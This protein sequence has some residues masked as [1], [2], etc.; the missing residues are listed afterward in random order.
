MRQ[1]SSSCSILYGMVSRDGHEIYSFV[2][3]VYCTSLSFIIQKNSQFSQWRPTKRATFKKEK[4]KCLINMKWVLKSWK[5]FLSRRKEFHKLCETEMDADK[6]A[7]GNKIKFPS[8]SYDDVN[9]AHWCRWEFVEFP[10]KFL[11]L[12][13]RARCGA[14]LEARKPLRIFSYACHLGSITNLLWTLRV[15]FWT[16][17]FPLPQ[18]ALF[19]LWAY[20]RQTFSRCV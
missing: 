13:P 10:H 17:I 16:F 9:E 7:L 18:F 14:F 3:V 8:S 5:V 6:N 11:F 4:H 1:T 20:I 19:T 2:W 15:Q 12:L